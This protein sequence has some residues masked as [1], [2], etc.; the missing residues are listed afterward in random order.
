MVSILSIKHSSVD[1]HG[2]SG[3]ISDGKY[4]C[5]TAALPY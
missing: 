1:F 4:S 2:D 3:P 5:G